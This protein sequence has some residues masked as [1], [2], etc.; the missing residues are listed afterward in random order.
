MKKDSTNVIS[1]ALIVMGIYLIW[2][3]F[4]DRNPITV[5]KVIMVGDYKHIPLAGSWA[6]EHKKLVIGGGTFPALPNNTTVPPS[7]NS[8][9]TGIIA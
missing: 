3:G 1:F 8:G 9:P 7:N 2:C 5:L 4:T 6:I